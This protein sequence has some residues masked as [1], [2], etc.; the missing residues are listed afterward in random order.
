MKQEGAGH[1]HKEV[2]ADGPKIGLSK[3]ADIKYDHVD[4]FKADTVVLTFNLDSV[5]RMTG[6]LGPDFIIGRME[7][8]KADLA[9]IVL[10]KMDERN[11]LENP[12]GPIQLVEP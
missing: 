3:L 10:T 5:S 11:K 2:N 7:R 12:G 1:I 8:V 9:A 6:G 4:P